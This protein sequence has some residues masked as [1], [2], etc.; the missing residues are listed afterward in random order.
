VAPERESHARERR[1]TLWRPIRRGTR[2]SPG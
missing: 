2:C 1:A